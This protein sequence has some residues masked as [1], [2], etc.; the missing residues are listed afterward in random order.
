MVLGA[1]VAG[2][3]A[4]TADDA[5]AP[6]ASPTPTPAAA[7][8]PPPAMTASIPIRFFA[9]VYLR[10]DWTRLQDKAD[11]LLD[12]NQVDEIGRAHV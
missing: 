5:P 12:G 7:A 9:N 2:A 10:E 4:A 1:M 6:Q 3:R 8:A 11:L